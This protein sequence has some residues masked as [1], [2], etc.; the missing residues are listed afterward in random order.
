MTVHPMQT[1]QIFLRWMRVALRRWAENQNRCWS[2]T[3]PGK[4]NPTPVEF[5]INGDGAHQLNYIAATC[6][7]APMQLLVA[8]MQRSTYCTVRIIS[9]LKGQLTGPFYCFCNAKVSF[10]TCIFVN[11]CFMQLFPHTFSLCC[12]LLIRACRFS[13][14][15]TSALFPCRA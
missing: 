11:L 13:Y 12:G 14:L 6:L 8:Q 15:T 10:Q 5:A 7:F 3:V 1:T 4:Y 2:T 9:H